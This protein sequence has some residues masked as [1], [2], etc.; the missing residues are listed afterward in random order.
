VLV[1]NVDEAFAAGEVEAFAVSV[2]GEIN[3]FEG[4]V[5]GGGDKEA[6]AGR[7]EGEMVETAFDTRKRHGLRE[8]ECGRLRGVHYESQ[9]AEKPQGVAFHGGCL[10]PQVK[11]SNSVTLLALVQTPTLPASATIAWLRKEPVEESPP[12]ARGLQRPVG[13]V[14]SR[15]DLRLP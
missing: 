15:G 8:L 3:A 10:L 12:G 4:V 13:R 1:H 14:P 5:A 6:L 9:R 7:V 11:S 2:I